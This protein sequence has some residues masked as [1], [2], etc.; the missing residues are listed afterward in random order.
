MGYAKHG[1]PWALGVGLITG[2]AYY[3]FARRADWLQWVILFAV[4]I[5]LTIL[6]CFVIYF[7]RDPPRVPEDPYHPEKSIVSP[8]DGRLCAF[9]EEAG[10]LAI[11]IEMHASNVH[12]TRAHTDGI[13]KRIQR[14]GGKHHPI[15]LLK[16]TTGTDSKA[17]R[18]NAR[19]IIEM[20]DKEGRSF[21]Y[22]MICGKVA[23]RAVPYVKEGQAIAKGQKM[24]II[25]FGSMV[26]ITLPGTQYQMRSKLS[27]NVFGGRTVICDRMD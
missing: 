24:G 8:A 11:Y 14:V 7:F 15:Y 9:E 18:K 22:H 10:N 20:E 16:N 6:T 23:R 17:I 27:D 4:A 5:P 3:W 12:V 2:L 1:Y 21:V 26:K 13:I 25:Q 19:V